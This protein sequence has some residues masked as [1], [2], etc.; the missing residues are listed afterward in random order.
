[1][2]L[3]HNKPFRLFSYKNTHSK[4]LTNLIGILRRTKCQ[5]AFL[6]SFIVVFGPGEIDL[7]RYTKISR[8]RSSKMT[9]FCA[10]AEPFEMPFVFLLISYSLKTGC[11]IEKGLC[12]YENDFQTIRT[13]IERDK[14]NIIWKDISTS[15]KISL[16]FGLV[17]RSSCAEDQH[18]KRLFYFLKTNL[19]FYMEA[20]QLL[21]LVR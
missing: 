1:M 19:H 20:S 15:Y 8:A 17:L 3:C 5:N 4:S 11:C 9:N 10:T 2:S 6:I 7:T 14:H 13:Q 16:W 12:R 18:I 21:L